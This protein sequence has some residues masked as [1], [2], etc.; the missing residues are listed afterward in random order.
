M[1]SL[2]DALGAAL[3]CLNTRRFA[4]AV[5]ICRRVL[6]VDP[7]NA[8]AQH[9]WGLAARQEGRLDEAAERL[10]LALERAPLFSAARVNLANT[11]R[12]AGRHDAALRSYRL[13]LAVDP[14]MGQGWAVFGNFLMRNG[15]PRRHGDAIRALRRTVTIDPGAID[16][17]HELGLVLRH[18]DRTEEGI[19]ELREVVARCPDHAVA[20]MNLGTALVENGEHDSALASMR[21]AVALSPD[22]PEVHYNSGNALHA[23]GRLENALS[24]F[25][26]SV[27]L[28]LAAGQPR[29]GIVLSD[30][31]RHDA[32]ETEFRR[33][34]TAGGD[35]PS[36]LEWLTH[37]FSRTGRTDEGRTLFVDLI[38]NHPAGRTYLGE[39]RTALADLDL[40][41][42]NLERCA[43]LAASVQGDSGRLFT[44]KTLAALQ[45]TLKGMGRRLIRPVNPHPDRPA[46]TSSTLASHGRFAHNVLEYVLV[47]L[48]AEKH[49]LTLET[50]EWVGGYV[51]SIDDPPPSRPYP[52]LYYPRRTLNRHLDGTA[53]T[54]PPSGVDFRSPLF[55]LRRKEEYR[56]RVQ[57]WLRPR[58]VWSPFLDPAMERL[59]AMGDTVVA[60]HIRRGDFVQFNY[61]IT[62]T[63]WYVDWLRALWPTLRRP[64]LYIASDDLAGVRRDF[65]EFAPVARADVAP[66]WPGLEFLQDFHALMHADVVGVSAASGF[67]LLAAQLNRQATLFVEPDVAGR[68]IRPFSP[69]TP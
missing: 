23:A 15:G 6:E 51:F 49:G 20:F 56:E 3:H 46:V 50:P 27:R 29:I 7:G 68:C 57:S 61:P 66:D 14:G 30:L 5:T 64:V 21:C 37:L 45:L 38:R 12:A 26:R 59:R 35:V 28:G 63:A 62:E 48:Y 16:A 52:P 53:R 11:L 32:A 24:A 34:L 13:A 43:T 47:R 40:Q 9:L 18:A 44:V 36:T 8:D 69:W 60:I 31:G 17:R 33:D 2:P 58:A 19:A 22:S 39:C 41:D 1:V 10:G 54:V 65:A 4:D 25:R 67:S 55:L 42:G